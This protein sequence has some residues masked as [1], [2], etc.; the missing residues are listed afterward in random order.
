MERQT[1]VLRWLWFAA[2]ALSLALLVPGVLQI[3]WVINPQRVP[4]GEP[5]WILE[6]SQHH[7]ILAL[8]SQ[9]LLRLL[10]Y[11]LGF[12]AEIFSLLLVFEGI[13][14]QAE[15]VVLCSP[16]YI[17]LGFIQWFRIMPGVMG[18]IRPSR[19]EPQG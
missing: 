17:G 2:C 7:H 13:T 10:T 14:T 4:L 15:A 19:L 6:G 12:L 3:I 5:D 9:E 1:R 16:L 11:P 8:F 18:R